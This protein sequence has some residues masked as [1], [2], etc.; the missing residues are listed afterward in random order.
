MEENH[1]HMNNKLD[2]ATAIQDE[3]VGNYFSCKECG[4]PLNAGSPDDVHK[5]SSVLQCWHFDWI[6]R[7][8]RC[9]NCNKATTLYWHPQVHKYRDYCTPEEMKRKMSKDNNNPH[10][11]TTHQAQL[12]EEMNV[13]IA[14]RAIE[15]LNT[16]NTST[17]YGYIHPDYFNHESQASPERAK[18]RGPEEFADTVEKLRNAFTDLHYEEQENIASNDKVISLMIVNGKHTG[19]FFGIPPTDRNFSYQAVHI[20]RIADEK[21]VEHQAIRDDLRFMMQLGVIGAAF[22]QYEPILNAWKGMMMKDK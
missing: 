18:L 11:T 8:Y 13:K 17:A 7:N 19:N 21:I 14:R 16:G 6:E 15:A 20:F 2:A 4:S 1:H 22:P 10:N 12:L 3:T 9:L 5:F